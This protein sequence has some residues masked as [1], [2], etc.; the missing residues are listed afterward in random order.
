MNG[1]EFMRVLK[2][3]Q[4]R[5]PV[6]I[7]SGHSQRD[8]KDTI[9]ALELGALEFLRKPE[10]I[11]SDKDSFRQVLLRVLRYATAD[12]KELQADYLEPR[13]QNVR[14]KRSGHGV[15]QSRKGAS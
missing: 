1:V 3:N 9:E 2:E 15:C 7:I 6:I 5:I 12:K 4:I 14:Q 11:V 13:P 8:T 10:N